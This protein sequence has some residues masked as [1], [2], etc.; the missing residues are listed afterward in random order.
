MK[1]AALIKTDFGLPF[2]QLDLYGRPSSRLLR[3]IK[4]VELGVDRK[5]RRFQTAVAIGFHRDTQV[6]SNADLAESVSQQ[7][8]RPLRLERSSLAQILQIL[9]LPGWNGNIEADFPPL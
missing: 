3:A 8:D 2:M 9:D 5:L 7:F 4:Q 6:A 1:P